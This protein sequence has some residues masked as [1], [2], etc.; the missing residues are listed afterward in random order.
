M[1]TIDERLTSLETKFELFMQNM[2]DMRQ[3]MRD[4]D[5]QRAAELIEIRQRQDAAQAKHEA[6]IKAM[7]KKFDAKFDALTKQLHDNF[8]Q[9]LLGVGG[10][11]LA[12]GAL[13]FTALRQ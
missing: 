9:T 4:R 3:E 11:M 5:N 2:Q 8:I 1:A 10:M 12:L 6:D 7:D 13:L